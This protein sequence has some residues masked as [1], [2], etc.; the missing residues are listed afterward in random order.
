MKKVVS[1]EYVL[2]AIV[3]VVFYI[4]VGGFAWYWLPISFLAFDISMAGYFINN[5]IGALSYNVGHSM[6]GPAILIVVYIMTE[7]QAAL[8]IALLWLFHIFVDRAMGYGLK[9]VT[10]FQ[11]TH[12]GPI[13]KDKQP[14]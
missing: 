6:I 2:A 3:L 10:G 14:K 8:F 5:R 9:H 12:L 1:L 4:S 11:H 7:N 13:G